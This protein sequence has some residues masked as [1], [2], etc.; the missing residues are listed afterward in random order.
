M[1]VFVETELLGLAALAATLMLAASQG[2]KTTNQETCVFP[3][4]YQGK[5]YDMCTD[6]GASSG[7]W[8]ATTSNYD[9]DAKWGMCSAE[10]T[11]G[12]TACPRHCGST[13]RGCNL[14]AREGG[15]C[16]LAHCKPGH[17][18]ATPLADVCVANT[19]TG[20]YSFVWHG[21]LSLMST[22]NLP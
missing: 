7:K 21:L 19:K 12:S 22:F 4:V 3:F 14:C 9:V 15:S 13:G 20:Q 16:R 8:C 1:V 18:Q 10:C 6:A 2:C 5:R 11:T 17:T